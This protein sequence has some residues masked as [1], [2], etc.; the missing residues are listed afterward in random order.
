MPNFISRCAGVGSATRIPFVENVP[1]KPEETISLEEKSEL[2]SCL[3][4]LAVVREWDQQQG[5]LLAE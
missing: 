3:T 2:E 5:L 1:P 4:S